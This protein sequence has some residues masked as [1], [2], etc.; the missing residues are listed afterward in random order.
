[1]KP[2]KKVQIPGTQELEGELKRERYR[3]RYRSVLKSTVFTLVVVAAFAILVAT[4]WMPVLQIYGTSMSP[5]L[6]EGEIVIS[7][8]SPEFKKGDLV[9]FYIGN[10]LLVKR[11]I[12]GPGDWV[13]I[14]QDGT[15]TVNNVKIDEPY[16]TEKSLGICDI[17]LPYQVPDSKY[18]LMGDHRSTSVDSRSSVIG[19]VS[20]EQI[21]GRIVC[22]VWPF[23]NFRIFD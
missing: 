6:E 19:C 17:E 4:L 2:D 7:V 16:L 5:T 10:K 9:A 15:V 20:R 23:T 14:D 22:C 12:A 11:V 3:Q 18:F 13:N 21:V 8:K 1:M